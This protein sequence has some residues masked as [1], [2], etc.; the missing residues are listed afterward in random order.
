M[1]N[2]INE[3]KVQELQLWLDEEPQMAFLRSK[4]GRGPMFWAFEKGNEKITELLMRMGLP[5]TDKDVKGL[6]PLDL[7]QG[8]K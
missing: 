7:L 3:D 6:T 4:D 8:G 2:L 1:W 5:H